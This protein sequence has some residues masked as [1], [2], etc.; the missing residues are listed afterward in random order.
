MQNNL[1]NS[2]HPNILLIM[3]DQ[4]TTQ[5][6][7]CYG[8]PIDTPNID[9]IADE[10]IRFDQA[11]CTTPFC[12]PSRASIVTG[13][14]PHSHKVIYNC[15]NT[16]KKQNPAY[17]R[18]IMEE[19]TCN[20]TGEKRNP[21]H[22]RQIMEGLNPEDVTTER[23]LY[24]AGYD[25]HHYGKWHLDGDD[26]PYYTDM[27]RPNQEYAME[28]SDVFCRIRNTDRN[29]WMNW[30]NWSL[31]VEVNPS[32][33]K[34][35]SE[36]WREN[37]YAD[38]VKKMGRLKLPCEQNY[39]VYV[40][41]KTVERV[42]QTNRP[43][44]ITCSFNGPHDPNV[45]NS[46][47]YEMFDPQQIKLASNRNH[48]ESRFEKEWSRIMALGLTETGVQE[49]MRIYYGMVKLIDDQV[50]R[51]LKVLDSV[52]KLDDTLVIFTADHGDMAGGH[53]MVW[54]GTSS[55]YEEVLRVPLLIRCPKILKP[56]ISDISTDGTD[57]M[58]T[59]LGLV[60]LPIPNHV[61]GQNLTPYL[62]G[63]ADVSGARAFSFSERLELKLEKGSVPKRSTPISEGA[64]AVR[65]KGWKY[66]LYNDNTEY[67]Y[68]L[69]E[70]PG[71]TKNVA[72]YVRNLSIKREMKDEL[73]KWL[74][75]TGC[76]SL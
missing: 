20:N 63:S 52:G 19:L 33:A 2:V 65:G 13:M 17:F 67:L 62:T 58:P 4:L 1:M 5:A 51:V 75:D 46:P 39:E 49:F 57:L 22:F 29:T 43:F 9:R 61:Q 68:N 47:Y 48:V 74:K 27:Y 38:F 50:G 3:C 21:V 14:Y 26:M 54:K 37:I 55:F 31:P 23:I 60:G 76:K 28:M 64:F 70:D 41:D 71:E 34:K 40:C 69:V 10:G 24:E 8:G 72:K 6:L 66:I 56:Q 42:K 44:M 16:G 32:L 53:G 35:V 18:R 73:N 59:I 12:S 7:S 36:L 25:T 15:S 11:I 45:I 30:Y